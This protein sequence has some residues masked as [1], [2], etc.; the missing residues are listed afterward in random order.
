MKKPSYLRLVIFYWYCKIRELFI[1]KMSKTSMEKIILIDNMAQTLDFMLEKKLPWDES[2]YQEN[3]KFLE[4]ALE[5]FEDLIKGHDIGEA[6][7]IALSLA[8][9]LLAHRDK[10]IDISGEKFCTIFDPLCVR[11]MKKVESK[12]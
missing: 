9:T 6:S 12:S 5:N 1:P 3:W 10:T 8:T 4:D 11:M 2:V 7:N